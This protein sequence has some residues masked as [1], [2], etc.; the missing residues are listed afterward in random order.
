MSLFPC[1]VGDIWLTSFIEIDDIKTLSFPCNFLDEILGI[2]VLHKV[3]TKIPLLWNFLT[4]IIFLFVTV[5]KKVEK[6]KTKNRAL[7]FE[8]PLFCCFSKNFVQTWI[9]LRFLTC[10]KVL[11]CFYE[12]V[13]KNLEVV[14]KKEGNTSSAKLP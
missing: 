8:K 13:E 4:I 1:Q 7:K 9:S 12:F 11:T 14:W 5:K 10:A 3:T 6:K 2:M